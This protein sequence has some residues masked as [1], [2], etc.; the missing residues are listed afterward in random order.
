[1]KNEIELKPCPFCG[2]KP[3]WAKFG[4]SKWIGCT[5]LDCGV[6]PQTQSMTGHNG[7]SEFDIAEMWN[8]RFEDGND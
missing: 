2:A 1:M 5:N 4:I 8:R 6:R 7:R 3:Y